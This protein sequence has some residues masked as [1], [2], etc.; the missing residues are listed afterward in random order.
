MRGARR[1]GLIA[2]LALVPAAGARSPALRIA[3][4][5]YASGAVAEERGFV[6]TREEGVHRGWWADGKPRFEYSYHD[7]LLNGVSREWF[8]SGALWREQRYAGGHEEGLQ[9]LY[10]EDGR[11][12]AS[13]VVEGGRRFGLL[14]AKGCVTR[15]STARDSAAAEP[16]S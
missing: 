6:G 13:Y 7:G 14:G 1:L 2:L 15:D 9:R 5:R 11:V 10:W 16:A 12:R 4:E 8:P 3:R